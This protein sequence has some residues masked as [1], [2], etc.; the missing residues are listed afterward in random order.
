[1]NMTQA[2]H[3]QEELSRQIDQVSRNLKWSQ[4]EF[5]QLKQ[6]FK[7]G[8]K[9]KDNEFQERIQFLLEECETLISGDKTFDQYISSSGG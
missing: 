9:E 4:Q 6:K 2:N 7:T 5:V 3:G 1:M 8:D